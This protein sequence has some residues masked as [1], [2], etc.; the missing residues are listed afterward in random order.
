MPRITSMSWVSAYMLSPRKTNNS[1]FVSTTASQIGCGLS[2][3]THD[4]NAIR[5]S[6]FS[7]AIPSDAPVN[8][9]ARTTSCVRKVV[10]NGL[11][12]RSDRGL[13][14]QATPMRRLSYR[15]GDPAGPLITVAFSFEGH[16][17]DED[18]ESSDR[19]HAIQNRYYITD[20]HATVM[21]QLGLNPRRLEFPAG[22]PGHRLRAAYTGNHHVTLNWAAPGDLA[23]LDLGAPAAPE[24]HVSAASKPWK[25]APLEAGSSNVFYLSVQT[26][27]SEAAQFLGKLADGGKDGRSAHTCDGRDSRVFTETGQPLNAPTFTL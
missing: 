14:R 8:D 25:L 17:G 12:L 9:K 5:D 27:I 10:A 1:G 18:R 2:C 15:I 22:A 7:P 3:L 13:P 21:H 24:N 6:G 20:I 11:L 4:P 19:L 26:A 23:L 16:W